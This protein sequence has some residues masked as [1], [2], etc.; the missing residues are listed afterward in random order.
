[1]LSDNDK[2]L[3]R[4]CLLRVARGVGYALPVTVTAKAA[5][6]LAARIVQ[7][8]KPKTPPVSA[9]MDRV[10]LVIHVEGGNV[11]SMVSD[12]DLPVDVYVIDEDNLS[13]GGTDDIE[14]RTDIYVDVEHVEDVLAEARE[15]VEENKNA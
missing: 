2:Q 7:L 3:I 8:G 14:P 4:A 6:E 11:D 13:T 9:A 5:E 15:K 12:G 10:R 1:M